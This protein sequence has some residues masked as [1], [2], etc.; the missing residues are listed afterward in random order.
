MHQGRHQWEH[1]RAIQL[2]NSVAICV[3]RNCVCECEA[4]S[5]DVS[6]PSDQGPGREREREG[7]SL[8]SRLRYR[9]GIPGGK[10]R[11]P[12]TGNLLTAVGASYHVRSA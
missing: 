2:E 5:R 11:R 10:D 4:G 7:G 3:E 6:D 9:T 1:N 12:L 8:T